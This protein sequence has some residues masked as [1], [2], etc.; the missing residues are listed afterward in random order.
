LLAGCTHYNRLLP[1]VWKQNQPEAIRA[2][3]VEERRG[4][5][6]RASGS[7]RNFTLCNVECEVPA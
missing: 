5:A 7:G 6:E 2:Y 3:R 4:T 1:D